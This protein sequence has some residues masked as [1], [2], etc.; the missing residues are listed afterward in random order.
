MRKKR[1]RLA[2]KVGLRLRELRHGARLTQ[3]ALA[4]KAGLTGKYLSEVECGHRDLRLGTVERLAAAL[5]VEPM[6]L[7]HFGAH[8]DVASTADTP[9]LDSALSRLRILLRGREASVLQH[10]LPVVREMLRLVDAA[11]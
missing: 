1:E 3:A 7:L 9:D 4:A 11:K 5:K 2:T 8:V 6:Q 10:L